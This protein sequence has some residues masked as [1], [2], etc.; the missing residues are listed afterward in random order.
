MTVGTAF[1]VLQM[2]VKPV[3]FG[4]AESVARRLT[5]CTAGSPAVAVESK[6]PDGHTPQFALT[7]FGVEVKEKLEKWICLSAN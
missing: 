1:V 6:C 3:I 2:G 5:R 7:P 4:C